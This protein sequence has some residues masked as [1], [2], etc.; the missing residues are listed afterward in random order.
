ME[1]DAGGS[2]APSAVAELA[3]SGGD[4]GMEDVNENP[5]LPNEESTL[6]AENLVEDNSPLPLQGSAAQ[7]GETTWTQLVPGKKY[8]VRPA[9]SG[10]YGIY[11]ARSTVL[12][13]LFAEEDDARDA[14][15]QLKESAPVA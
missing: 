6:P 9:P 2:S 7:H 8:Q 1:A 4:D 3:V 11:E 15:D 14:I 10:G 13:Q 5:P 12:L